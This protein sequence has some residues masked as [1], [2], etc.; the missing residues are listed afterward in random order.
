MKNRKNL[1]KIITCAFFVSGYSQ[2]EK[3]IKTS[4]TLPQRQEEQHSQRS[5]HNKFTS[6]FK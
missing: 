1:L 4:L 2:I 6:V 5:Q 3:K